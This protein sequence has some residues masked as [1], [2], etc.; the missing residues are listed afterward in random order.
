MNDLNFSF[1][2][3]N[4]TDVFYPSDCLISGVKEWGFN[5]RCLMEKG[6]I[7]YND[8]FFNIAC[9]CLFFVMAK[10]IYPYARDYIFKIK[11]GSYWDDYIDWFIDCGIATG[12]FLFFA[13][14]LYFRY[15]NSSIM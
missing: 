4:V 3:M 6:I 11:K 10:L 7:M 13:L 1:Q 15:A 9:Y 5:M 14:C 2:N 8:M 12:I